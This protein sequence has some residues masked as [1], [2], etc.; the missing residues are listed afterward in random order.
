MCV[1]IHETGEWQQFFSI[2]VSKKRTVVPFIRCQTLS[3]QILHTVCLILFRGFSFI[4]IQD[5]LDQERSLFKITLEP[6]LSVA[7]SSANCF[8]QG[9]SSEWPNIYWIDLYFCFAG[10]V[11]NSLGKWPLMLK[12]KSHLPL[13]WC[14][15]DTITNITWFWVFQVVIQTVVCIFLALKKTEI[16]K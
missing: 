8:I 3:Y 16:T 14:C 13:P 5:R 6:F 1:F 12:M 11:S 10:L 9:V 2:L 7:N 15:L 4:Y